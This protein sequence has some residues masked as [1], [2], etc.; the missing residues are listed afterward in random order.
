MDSFFNLALGL[1]ALG[2]MAWILGGNVLPMIIVLA[3]IWAG[4]HFNRG[5]NGRNRRR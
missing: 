4:F 1:L 3:V 5:L 2:V